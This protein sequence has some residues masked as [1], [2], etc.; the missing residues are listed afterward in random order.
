MRL[1]DV[2]TNTVS[3]KSQRSLLVRLR[4]SNQSIQNLIITQCYPNDPRDEEWNLL[5]PCSRLLS[6]QVPR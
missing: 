1:S 3:E 5:A 2:P 6:M 4:A